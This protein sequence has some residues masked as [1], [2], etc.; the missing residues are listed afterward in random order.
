M[1]TSDDQRTQRRDNRSLL[2]QRSASTRRPAIEGLAGMQEF[3]S[4]YSTFATEMRQ[5]S[6]M[7]NSLPP[8]LPVP[9]SEMAIPTAPAQIIESIIVSRHLTCNRRK[10]NGHKHIP[11]INS[12]PKIVSKL[13]PIR[14]THNPVTP[15]SGHIISNAGISL[16]LRLIVSECGVISCGV[17]QWGVDR[18]EETFC[19]LR[20][21][22]SVAMRARGRSGFTLGLPTAPSR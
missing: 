6:V 2:P 20:F 15:P 10:R 1:P 19:V 5:G 8:P 7:H 12:P 17:V 21:F 4:M 22:W 13:L 11:V 9:Q 16:V 3:A 14:L 18:A